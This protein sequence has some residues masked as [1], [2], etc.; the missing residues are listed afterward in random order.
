MPR[1]P[2]AC[3]CTCAALHCTCV[4]RVAAPVINLMLRLE[5]IQI[6]TQTVAPQIMVS[7]HGVDRIAHP[8]RPTQHTERVGSAVDQ[9]ASQPK[10]VVGGVEVHSLD[11]G[12]EAGK[13]ALHVADDVGGHS[14]RVPCPDALA[15][16]RDSALCHVGAERAKKVVT[17]E[18][19]A[20]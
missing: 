20:W 11:K 19:I 10:V 12:F 2:R 14:D 1:L 9:V 13:A 17:G 6:Q 4:L 8:R 16:R 5:A 3:S 18:L 7:E 15:Q